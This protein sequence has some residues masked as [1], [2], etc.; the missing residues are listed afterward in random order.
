VLRTSW[1]ETTASLR[2]YAR[3]FVGAPRQGGHTLEAMVYLISRTV[4]EDLQPAVVVLGF[5]ELPVVWA[6]IIG[7]PE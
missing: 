3:R 1:T 7:C 4:P 2:R 6:A 5:A